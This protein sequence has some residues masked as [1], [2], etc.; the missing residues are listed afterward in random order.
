MT[1]FKTSF[2]TA[3]STVIKLISAFIINKVIA[4]YIGPSGLA[5]VGQLQNFISISTT[6]SNGGIAQG[7][8]KY[9]AEYKSIELKKKLFST[10][11]IISLV[12]SLIIAIV[13]YIFNDYLSQ[14]IIKDT[15]YSNVFVLFS[16]TIF[17][18]CFE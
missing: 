7:I 1:L 2:L 5:I 9:T 15:Q 12:S 13:L 18:I 10:S 4:I 6:F 11:I 3:I 17:F 16:F 8:V 14:L